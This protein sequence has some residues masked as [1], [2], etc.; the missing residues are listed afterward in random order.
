MVY[1]QEKRSEISLQVVLQVFNVPEGRFN[2]AKMFI[3][4]ILEMATTTGQADLVRLSS[5]TSALEGNTLT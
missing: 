3:S 2:N 4:A 5:A 1:L